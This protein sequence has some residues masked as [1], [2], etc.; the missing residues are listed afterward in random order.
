MIL[1]FFIIAHAVAPLSCTDTPATV[2]SHSLTHSVD[3]AALRQH[4]QHGEKHYPKWYRIVWQLDL[5]G[6]MRE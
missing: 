3:T 6:P 1:I 5:M 2:Y 4:F